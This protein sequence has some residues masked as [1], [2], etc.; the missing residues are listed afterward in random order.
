MLLVK[1]PRQVGQ[2]VNDAEKLRLSDLK[3][4]WNQDTAETY[5]NIGNQ[6]RETYVNSLLE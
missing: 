4:L 2:G 1:W 5:G 3:T 6:E